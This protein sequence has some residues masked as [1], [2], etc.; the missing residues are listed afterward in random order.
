MPSLWLKED[1]NQFVLHVFD[2]KVLLYN[3]TYLQS[4]TLVYGFQ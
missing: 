3:F 4:V 2:A 1:N